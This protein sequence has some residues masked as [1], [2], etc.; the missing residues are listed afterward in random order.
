MTLDKVYGYNANDPY[1]LNAI[2]GKHWNA[3]YLS[4]GLG[5]EMGKISEKQHGKGFI[6]AESCG[7]YK[8]RI[9]AGKRRITSGQVPGIAL[10]PVLG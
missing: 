10:A 6:N 4:G 3:R 2:K 5:D 8:S 7:G 1:L 9:C